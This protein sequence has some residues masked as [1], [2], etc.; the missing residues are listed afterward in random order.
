[1]PDH[2]EEEG[3][4]PQMENAAKRPD[5]PSR[6]HSTAP[7]FDPN[8]P[9]TLR[10]F[11]G[12]LEVLFR[13]CGVD[14]DLERKEAVTR[15]L[16]IDVADLCEGLPSFA[17][18]SYQQ[19]HDDIV[20]LYPGAEE[21]RKFAVADVEGLV[22][23]RATAPMTTIGELSQYYR[24]FLGM[25]SY[26]IGRSRLSTS[27][28]S[29]LFVRGIVSPLWDQVSQRLQLKDPDHYPDDPYPLVDVYAAAKFVLHGTLTS[30]P[31]PAAPATD[32]S[33]SGP[34]KLEDLAPF[35]KF[36]AQSVGE[37]SA[38]AAAAAGGANAGAAN[39]N[40]PNYG[41]CHYCGDAGCQVRTCPH[42]AEDIKEGR[43]ARNAEGK[44]VLPNG[45]FVPRSIPGLTM[46]DRIYEWHRRNPNSL[47]VPTAAQMVLQI[48]RA[49]PMTSTFSLTSDDRIAQLERELF[50]LRRNREVFDGVEL[51]A[52]KR[53]L[54]RPPEQASASRPAPTTDSTPNAPATDDDSREEIAT[55]ATA[56][57][58]RQLP[59]PPTPHPAAGMPNAPAAPVELPEHP[60]AKA[61]DATY[62]P[63][64]VKNFGGPPLKDKDRDNAY[65]TQVPVHQAKFAEEIF[66]RSMKT[67][68][69]TLTT[70]ELLS[71]APEVRAKYREAI[72]PKRI[73]TEAV[74]S[75]N[76]VASTEDDEEEDY[77]AQV[78]CRGEPLQPGGVIL[79][80]PYEVYLRR[81]APGNDPRELRVAK[82]SHALRS[83]VGLVDN[84]EWVEA[85]IDPG[86]Q[87]VAM[88]EHV[89]NALALPYDPTIQLFMQSANGDVD[90][91]LGLVRN[92]PFC[93]AD[94]VLYLQVH[95]IRNAAYDILLGRPF[96][97]LTK[98]VVK[99]FENEDQTL[100]IKTQETQN[101]AD[102][103]S[104]TRT[105]PQSTSPNTQNIG[106]FTLGETD[107]TGLFAFSFPDGK[108]GDIR[109][110]PGAVHPEAPPDPERTAE[111]FLS[112]KKKYKPVARKVRPVLGSTSEQFR[113]ER[114]ITGD[115][116]ADMPE[117][118]TNPTDFVPTG[119]YTAERQEAFN[120]AHSEDF[121]WPEERKLLHNFVSLQNEAFAW[122]DDERGC[123]KPEFFPPSTSLSSRTPPGWSGTSRYPPDSTTKCARS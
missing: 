15:Y 58:P 60:F 121:L 100:T 70:E 108:G 81:L 120:K 6:G 32:P 47:A 10:R 97:V 114:N 101:H 112:T 57:A 98:S 13:R 69:F 66:A 42:V 14:T 68:L 116:L 17:T 28:Q 21:S 16:P 83:V 41:F 35:L 102:S 106:T 99:N 7:T 3:Q 50:A 11:F 27:E 62:A 119:R 18:G 51:P 56:S 45:S 71:V 87:I 8:S 105:P 123:F 89:C 111:V 117:L 31:A 118:P 63:P 44:V 48:S 43:V 122:N 109:V 86:S 72:T 46:R 4:P 52:P 22:A 74:R 9:R 95:V 67:P 12:D 92:V 96:D 64:K 65:R 77:A 80:D 40:Q 25:T 85:I 91:S 94:I 55:K 103:H 34:V 36:L 1:M 19:F 76:Y 110:F 79:P 29:R 49:V 54:P 38:S 33:G 93:V 23:R 61:R 37:G 115:P 78:S 75:V 39:Q 24:D 90:R 88:S 107:P 5:L 113:V 59:R 30:A 73:P 53:S 84:K 26:L 20:A 2:D 82:E 104:H